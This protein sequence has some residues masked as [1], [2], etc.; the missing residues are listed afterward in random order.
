MTGHAAFTTGPY[1]CVQRATSRGPH[2][3]SLTVS[4]RD[5]WVFGIAATYGEMLIAAEA[6]PANAFFSARLIRLC[7]LCRRSAAPMLKSGK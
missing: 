3:A 1:G 6:A 4:T 5:S 7:C 2:D